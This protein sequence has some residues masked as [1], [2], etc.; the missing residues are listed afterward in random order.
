MHK[1]VHDFFSNEVPGEVFKNARVIEVGSLDVNG[2][3][4]D[5]IME[6]LPREYIGIDFIDGKGV[7]KVMDAENLESEFGKSSFDVVVSTEM[8]EH[9]E[10]WR[11]CINNMKAIC[12]TWLVITTRSPGFPLHNYPGDHW[13]YTKEDIEKIFADFKI[14]VLLD[15]PEQAGVFML[16]R[17]TNKKSVSLKN[18]HL[19]P[20]PTR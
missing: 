17:K 7:D 6:F 15:D 9:A 13:R 4:R 2:S 19:T 18:I 20:A 11:E 14:E 12:K 16:A 5:Y 8:L 10:N 1:S 3:V